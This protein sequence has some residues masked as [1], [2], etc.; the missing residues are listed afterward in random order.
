MRVDT[1][2]RA[3]SDVSAEYDSLLAKMI[4]H[5]PTRAGAA[6]LL[7]RALRSSQIAGVD[8][9]LDTLEAILTEP[10]F[11]SA[12]PTTSYLAEHPAVEDAA[13]RR[14]TTG[15]RCCSAPSSPPS[16][17]PGSPTTRP[18]SPRRGGATCARRANGR[19]GPE[20]ATSSTSR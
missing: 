9:D 17:G 3:G 10:D 5:A 16:S 12:S 2:F 7:A 4:A 14:A 19:S 15:S 8:T 18:G 13:G 11:L 20:A 1:G 6:R